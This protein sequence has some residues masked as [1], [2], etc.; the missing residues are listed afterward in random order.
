MKI[1]SFSWTTPALLAGAKT[2]TRRHWS[3]SH[4]ARFKAGDF[5]LAYDKSPRAGGRPVAL[6][7]LIQDAYYEPLAQMPPSDFDAEGF[8]WFAQNNDAITEEMFARFGYG[9]MVSPHREKMWFEGWKSC[10]G[11]MWVVRFALIGRLF[12]LPPKKAA[13]QAAEI[14]NTIRQ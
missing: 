8:L 6:I 1:V 3:A 9:Q 14:A 7:R 2:V 4:A 12:H 5:V 13:G 10:G 11:S